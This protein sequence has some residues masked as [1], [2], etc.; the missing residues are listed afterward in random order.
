MSLLTLGKLYIVLNTV[1]AATCIMSNQAAINSE[2][3]KMLEKNKP[4]AW[5]GLALVFASLV[6]V[7]SPT[8]LIR[9]IISLIKGSFK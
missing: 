4:L 7:W 3:T 5:M 1:G 6:L 9:T 2:F 8:V